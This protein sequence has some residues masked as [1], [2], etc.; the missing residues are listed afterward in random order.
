MGA[1]TELGR[2]LIEGTGWFEGEMSQVEDNIYA[3]DYILSGRYEGPT[4]GAPGG[5]GGVTTDG[6]DTTGGTSG[7]DEEYYG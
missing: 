4:T 6:E 1:R 7:R 5:G 2:A 3:I